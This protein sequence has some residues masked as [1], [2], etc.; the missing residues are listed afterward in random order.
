MVSAFFVAEENAMKDA[1]WLMCPQCGEN[2]HL[3]LMAETE[4]FRFPLFCRKCR[5][6]SI[7]N[8]KELKVEVIS[9]KKIDKK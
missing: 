2:T 6:E 9:S 1:Q 7:I 3:K 5:T 8:V 4:L